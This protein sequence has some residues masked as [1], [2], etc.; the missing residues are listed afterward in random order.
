MK[1]VQK[2]IREISTFCCKKMETASDA[3]AIIFP[4]LDRGASLHKAKIYG[5][6]DSRIDGQA[7]SFEVD[8]CMF[9][10]EKITFEEQAQR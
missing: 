9:C 1:I 8:F 4:N 10:G 3:K 2:T 6:R 7:R 5:P